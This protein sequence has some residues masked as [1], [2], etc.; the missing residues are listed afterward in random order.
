MKNV[1][2]L[3]INDL[4]GAQLPCAC[5]RSHFM[6]VEEVIVEAGAVRRVAEVVRRFGSH[7]LLVADAHTWAAA[8][9]QVA[10]L[11]AEAGIAY[12]V[13]R[14][15]GDGMLVPDEA[16]LGGLVAAIAD[17]TDLLLAVGSGVMNDLTKFVARRTHLPAVL[18]ATA[19][20]MDGFVSNT[21]ALTISNLK[22]SIP[23]DLPKVILGDIDILKQAPRRM[24]RAGLGDMIGKYSALTDWKLSRFINNEYFCAPSAR[25]SETA[26]DKCR[27]A[28]ERIG[29]DGSFDAAGIGDITEGLVRTGIAMSYVGNSR[30]ASG[31][32]HHMSHYWETM[33]LLDGREALLH[34]TKVGLAS[35]LIAKIYEWFAKE[36]DI[37]Y[38][39][40]AEKIRGFDEAAWER[41]I[42]R[43]YRAAAPALIRK[44]KEDRRN[45][46]DTRLRRLAFI[47]AHI[48]EIREIAASAV[49]CAVIEEA[50]KKAGAPL[51][52]AEAGISDEIVYHS[53]L[54]AHEVRQRYTILNLL[55]DLDLLERFARK[56]MDFLHA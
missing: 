29:A 39:K 28:V 12:R 34:G 41:E 46:V 10:G 19:P 33:F 38:G 13:H 21:A 16:A 15:A 51:R 37:D 49:G 25:I 20:S 48:K 14:Y 22:A 7:P 17:D 1:D 36:A 6:D 9:A 56:V 3:G 26:V 47:E 31:S 35:I 8:G 23:C 27:K 52:P 54:V 18:V 30:P 32:E 5:G 50:M 42:K 43:L 24:I 2:S 55:H 45:D 11:L 53:V 4:L 40:A 44:A